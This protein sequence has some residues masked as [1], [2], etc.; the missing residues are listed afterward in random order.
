[1]KSPFKNLVKRFKK[2]DNSLLSK[3]MKNRS[4]CVRKL[5]R[6]FHCQEV[7]A[8][9]AFSEALLVFQKKVKKNK[10][11]HGRNLRGYLYRICQITFLKKAKKEKKE[12]EMRSCLSTESYLYQKEEEAYD[13]LVIQ[14]YL[15]EKSQQDKYKIELIRNALQTL[16]KKC[17][18]I[19][20]LFIVDGKSLNE[21]AKLLGYNNA[22]V[23]KTTKA[24]C[25]KR[26]NEALGN[27][28]GFVELL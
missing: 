22:N 13:Q 2:G 15:Q 26:L 3:M 12:K 18:K 9:D 6:E 27:D 21:I 10:I 5:R 1:M 16:P 14:E 20:L 11:K 28:P 4:Y 17:R 8:E 19:L 24:R 7:D 25:C 23:A